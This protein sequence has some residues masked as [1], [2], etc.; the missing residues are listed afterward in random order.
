MGTWFPPDALW[1]RNVP[2]GA[3]GPSFS[4]E[5]AACPPGQGTVS[6]RARAQGFLR[7]GQTAAAHERARSVKLWTQKPEFPPIF[8]GHGIDFSWAF[9]NYSKTLA[10]AEPAGHTGTGGSRTWP[11]GH[12][13][14]TPDLPGCSGQNLGCH[15]WQVL[16]LP[17][18]RPLCPEHFS[19][20]SSTPECQHLDSALGPSLA[21]RAH[22][23]RTLQPSS[24]R[25]LK[26]P[27]NSSCPVTVAAGG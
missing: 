1:L 4:W 8:M 18:P 7:G 25:E 23:V 27:R 12:S 26:S 24:A 9:F 16:S 19:A 6:V 5:A 15:L 2:E 11:L 10:H 13:V 14:L 17:C 20:C 22:C 3:S 21:T